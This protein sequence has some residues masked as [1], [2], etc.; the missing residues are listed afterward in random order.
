MSVNIPTHYGRQYA[1][2]LMLLL[3]QKGSRLRGC[4]MEKSDYKGEQASP[5]DQE[6]PVEMQSVDSR[7]EAMGRVDSDSDRRWLF[8]KSYDLPQ[9]VDHF[10]ELKVL[11][12]PKSQKVQ[13]AVNAAGRQIDR[14]IIAGM[15]GTNYTGKNGDTTTTALAGN[16]IVVDEGSSVDTGLTVAKLIK[17]KEI[18]MSHNVD[19]DNDPLYCGI[20][21]KQ[22][23][24]LMREAQVISL[25][26]NEKPVLVE[27]KVTSFMGFK[28]VHSELFGET[29][30][31]GDEQCLAWAKSG[32][33]LGLWEDVRTDI[34][35]RKDLR[36]L[37]WQVYLW[38]TIDACRLEEKKVVNI[39]C[40]V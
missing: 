40:N 2:T 4:V 34:S 33:H 27:G 29:L 21:A 32:V 36:G 14:R 5:V 9:M 15:L 19:T 24:S 3:Q 38:L 25:D 37:P 39:K 20:T 35:Q 16:T 28:F 31:S 17:A 12:D 13:N 22:Q 30:S 18:L 1:D 7:F 10:D 8:P 23:T 6:G 11:L 26:Y